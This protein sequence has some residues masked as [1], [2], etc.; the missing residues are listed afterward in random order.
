MALTEQEEKQLKDGLAAANAALEA[1]KPI[2]GQVT[3]LKG[4]LAKRDEKIAL[5][6]KGQNLSA[7]D[8]AIADLRGK[9]PTV[10][11]STLRALPADKRE[12][13]AKSLHE[14]FSKN[15]PA[16]DADPLAAWAKAGGV[17]ASIDL[18]SEAQR[19]ERAKARK[20]AVAAGD[21]RGVMKAM[22]GDITRFLAQSLFK[23]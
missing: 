8:R 10:P 6:E 14:Q 16:P 11:E 23:K 12:T 19:V 1:L 5:L 7:E 21:P 22:G 20:D 13:E 4:E 18:E 2:A 15:V 17:G 9:Y 3:E